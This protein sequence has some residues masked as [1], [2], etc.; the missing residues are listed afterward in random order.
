M[1][2]VYVVTQPVIGVDPIIQTHELEFGDVLMNVTVSGSHPDKGVVVYVTDKGPGSVM[3]NV[4][5][6][7][8]PDELVTVHV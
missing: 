2:N 8:H 1:L 3:V 7:M 5:V 6:S 4:R